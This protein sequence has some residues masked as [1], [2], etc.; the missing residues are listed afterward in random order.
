MSKGGGNPRRVRVAR[1]MRDVLA[2][3]L[4]R[5]V[6]DPRVRAAGFININHV[7]LNSDMSVARVYVSFLGSGSPDQSL[8]D[9]VIVRAMAG[10]E[11]SAS[12]LRGPLGRK[13][14]LRHAPSVRFVA[15]DSPVF[16]QKLRELVK[17]DEAARAPDD[18][19][20]SADTAPDADR[21]PE[22]DPH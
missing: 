21:R 14:K 22:N 7:E 18:E 1:A 16:Q 2:D 5:E 15:D 3:M 11:A 8:V 19:P 12:Y 6:K 13:L 10:L 17:A 20:T 4:A 9:P